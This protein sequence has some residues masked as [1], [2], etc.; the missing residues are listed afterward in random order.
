MTRRTVEWLGDSLK[1]LR[2]FPDK[3][4]QDIGFALSELEMGEEPDHSRPMKSIGPGVF[5]LKAQDPSK[6]YR[7]IYYT[8]LK[9]KIVVL[10]CFTKDTRKTERADLETAKHRLKMISQRGKT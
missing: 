6:W 7:A 3:P 10:H 9:G 8:K 2:T 5:E 1:V 4:R